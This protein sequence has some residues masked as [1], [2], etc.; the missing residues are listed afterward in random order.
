MLNRSTLYLTTSFVLI[1]SGQLSANANFSTAPTNP[2]FLLYQQ[3]AAFGIVQSVLPDSQGYARG[4]SP[5][6]FQYPQINTQN[7]LP[8]TLVQATTYPAKY[9]LRLMGKLNPVRNQGSCGNC[10]TYGAV[11][12]IESSLKQAESQDFS[13]S[14]INDTHGFDVAWCQGGN[15]LMSM[16]YLTRWSGVGKNSDYPQPITSTT[17]KITAQKH[18]QNIDV[19]PKRSTPLDNNA[20]KQ[21]VMTSGAVTITYT[22]DSDNYNATTFAWYNPV[23]TKVDHEVVIV[24]WDDSYPKTLFKTQP[25]GNG[26][27]IV[28]NSWGTSFGEK[29]YFYLS[30]YDKTIIPG[31]AFHNPEPVS[32]YAFLYNYDPLGVTGFTGYGS[33]TAWLANT[34]TAGTKTGSN[35]IRAAGIYSPVPNT[36]YEIRVYKNTNQTPQMPTN[37]TEITQART[38]GTIK[39]A[40]YHTIKLAKTATV[41]AGKKFSIVVKLQTPNYNYPIAYER[42]FANY[43]SQATAKAGQSYISYNGSSWDDLTQY[44]NNTNIA[45]K[46]YAGGSDKIP[47]SFNFMDK[48]SAAKNTYLSSNSIKVTGI[49]GSA[50][51]SI[52]S[53]EYKINSGSFTSAAGTVPNNA[54]VIVRHKTSN[55]GN[56]NTHTILNI[57]GMT[58]TFSTRTKP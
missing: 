46:A 29:G 14:H 37:G 57:G 40:G 47:N 25:A 39:Q 41:T 8:F 33:D 56:S 19:L 54:T 43:S 2:D 49:N 44:A 53:G 52:K 5:A 15:D 36:N 20:I 32:N 45:L 51:I 24:G 27:F 26:A 12:S 31:A 10:W 4:L 35:L 21:A 48:V 9:D 23:N 1:S 55:T 13:E 42:P 18:I 22:S 11:G 7:D 3:Q 28:R 30:Y 34:F 58:D 16:A 50:P 6:P 38:T 17:T